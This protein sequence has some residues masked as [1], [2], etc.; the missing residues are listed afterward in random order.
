MNIG[1]IRN[2]LLKH[3]GILLEPPEILLIAKGLME[4]HP[5][6]FLVFGMGNDT[7]LWMDINSG[8]RTAFIEDNA[9]WYSKVMELCPGAESYLVAYNTRISEWEQLL[10]NHDRLA[11]NLPP[12]ITSVQWDVILVDGPS[13]DYPNYTRRH[14]VE[15]PGRMSSIYMSSHL[16]KTK[17]YVFVHDCNRL[18]ERVYSDRYLFDSNL[19][20]QTRTERQLRKYK[21]KR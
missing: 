18:V 2:L 8:G 9:E 17:G 20:E 13:G 15:P 21:I 6:N 5:C 1:A 7:S 19:I 10:D 3:P 11:I 14:G 12:E 16:V 4:F